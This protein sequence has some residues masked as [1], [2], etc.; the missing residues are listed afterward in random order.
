MP[1][2]TLNGIQI[3]QEEMVKE[4]TKLSEEFNANQM[5]QAVAT[6]EEIAEARSKALLFNGI[7]LIDSY[8]ICCKKMEKEADYIN[9]LY[10]YGRAWITLTP[11]SELLHTLSF[12]DED[13]S[14]IEASNSIVLSYF[15]DIQRAE[16]FRKYLSPLA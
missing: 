16:Y 15:S 10:K 13:L 5:P 3:S 4:T 14:E 12:I 6:A 11:N 7:R 9:S 2:Y 1:K 8:E